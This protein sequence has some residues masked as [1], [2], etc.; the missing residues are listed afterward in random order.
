M[1]EKAI[2]KSQETNP[3]TTLHGPSRG[4]IAVRTEEQTTGVHRLGEFP[5]G[6]S[7]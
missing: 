6:S 4:F 1:E 2:L 3:C 7:R 5:Q